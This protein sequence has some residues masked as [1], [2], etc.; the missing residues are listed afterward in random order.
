M[1]KGNIYLCGAFILAGSSVISAY[2][3]ANKLGTFTATFL[4]LLVASLSLLPICYKNLVITLKS[5]SFVQWQM[6]FLQALFG[7]FLFRLFL[8]VGLKHTSAA[9]AGILLGVTP[10]IT[11]SLSWLILKESIHLMSLLG[12]VCALLG[13]L[14]L[15]GLFSQQ[16]LTTAHLVGNVLILLAASSESTFNI[17]SKRGYSL[18]NAVAIKP[19]LHTFLVIIIAMLLCIIPS[20]FE[21]PMTA[22]SHLTITDY[23]AI[24]WYGVF[25][26]VVAFI[27][28]YAGISRSTAINAAVC[29]GLMP[30]SS[31]LLFITLLGERISYQQ[32]LGALLIIGAIMFI[33]LASRKS[34]PH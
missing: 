32:L 12:I 23:L 34:A 28:W 17:L 4:S 3:L 33:A 14:L 19:L 11:A 16:G 20:F 10:A 5:L 6:I 13:V 2:L 7:I 29:S 8:M 31:L 30:L 15:K 1:F 25:A 24:I 26:T 9:E 22:I 18:K 21:Q 27:F